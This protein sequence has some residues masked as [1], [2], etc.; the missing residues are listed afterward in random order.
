MKTAFLQKAKDGLFIFAMLATFFTLSY[1]SDR[2]KEKTQKSIAEFKVYVKE[3]KDASEKYM[4]QKWE[5]MEKE[6]DLKKA[7]LDKH[8]DKMDQEMKNNYDETVAEWQAFK[9]D[10]QIKRKEK[11]E[12]AKVETLK[13]AIVPADIHTDFSNVNGSNIVS[14][15]E[16]F[17]NTVDSQKEIYSKEEWVL[18]NDY[19][20][21][22]KDLASRLDDAKKISK[23][24]N[25]KLTGLK[26]KYMAIKTMNKPFAGSENY[27]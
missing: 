13:S 17:V 22:L 18:I 12:M 8:A 26:I 1:C 27:K 9:A 23:E 3:H 15:F 24:D 19:W 14:V 6:Y 10:Y 25:R 4:D 7:E 20:K 16:H 2:G 11:E 5:D 21:S